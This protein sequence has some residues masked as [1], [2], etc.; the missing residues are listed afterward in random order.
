MSS[1][2]PGLFYWKI[3]DPELNNIIHKID[4]DDGSNPEV[5]NE[6][7]SWQAKWLRRGSLAL[8]VW[9]FL[10][11]AVCLALNIFYSAVH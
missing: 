5:F 1:I 4:D 3:S 2:L 9:G 6:H 11:M 7:N 8:V 10:V